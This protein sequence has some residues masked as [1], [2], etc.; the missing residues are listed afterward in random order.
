MIFW[1]FESG[2]VDQSRLG[3]TLELTRFLIG[4]S[5]WLAKGTQKDFFDVC[6]GDCSSS[7]SRTDGVRCPPGTVKKNVSG[8]FVWS[9]LW[10]LVLPCATDTKTMTQ[11]PSEA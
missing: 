3:K 2:G 7:S 10:W 1:R 5:S 6:I 9:V 4:E 8:S 11:G